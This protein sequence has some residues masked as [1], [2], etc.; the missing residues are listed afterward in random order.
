MH[1]HEAGTDPFD[2]F[3]RRD[4]EAKGVDPETASRVVEDTYGEAEKTEATPRPWFKAIGSHGD[5]PHEIVTPRGSDGGPEAIALCYREEDA[6]LIV[7]AVNAH[8]AYS[9]LHDGLSDMIEGG[10]LAEADI[11]D[12]YRWLVNMLAELAALNPQGQS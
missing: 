9:K 2:A 6:A 3:A 8:E 5:T 11:P 7:R 12:D 1:N 4:L 10:R